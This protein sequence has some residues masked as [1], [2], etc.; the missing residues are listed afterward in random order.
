MEGL[1]REGCQKVIVNYTVAVNGS[2]RS[3]FGS[4]VDGKDERSDG[5][6]LS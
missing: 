1:C 5:L 6:G 2:I 3:V 4:P